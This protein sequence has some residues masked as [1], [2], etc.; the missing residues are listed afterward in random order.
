MEWFIFSEELIS[1]DSKQKLNLGNGSF[2]YRALGERILQNLQPSVPFAVHAAA[3]A[4]TFAAC[5]GAT[6]ASTFFLGTPS[7]G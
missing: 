5:L 6:Q 4:G 7:L 1:T 2:W 3:S